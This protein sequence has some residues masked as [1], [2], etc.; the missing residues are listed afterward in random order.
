MGER[1]R[2]VV[3]GWIEAMLSFLLNG[4]KNQRCH[5]CSIEKMPWGHQL[6]CENE[7]KDWKRRPSWYKWEQ[8]PGLCSSWE[9]C[10]FLARSSSFLSHLLASIIISK[11]NYMKMA[12]G[13]KCVASTLQ[14]SSWVRTKLN[15]NHGSIRPYSCVFKN[16]KLPSSVLF[17]G[18]LLQAVSFGPFLL[19]TAFSSYEHT[20]DLWI[21]TS[22]KLHVHLHA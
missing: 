9:G 20:Q 12:E 18:H 22:H 3:S 19:G 17:M 10:F 6:P 13:E 4:E 7:I 2:K 16:P 21:F 15:M 1:E 11:C 5:K 8:K 14:K